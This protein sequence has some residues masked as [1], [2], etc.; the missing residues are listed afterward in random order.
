MDVH[1][2]ESIWLGPDK[3]L[4][5]LCHLSKNLYN[6][7]NY[8]IRQE[9]FSTGRWVRYY[10]LWTNLKNSPNYQGLPAQT[11]QQTL[12]IVDACWRA[13]QIAMEDYTVNPEKYFAMPRFPK[14]K[15]KDGEFILAFSNQQ[16]KLR[17]GMLRLTNGIIEVRTRLSKGTKITGARIMPR[18]VGYN[19]EITYDKEVKEK[20]VQ[21]K[22]RTIEGEMANDPK[23]QARPCRALGIDPGLNNLLTT[24]N[25]IGVPPI[26]F[27]GGPVKSINQFY[28][29]RRAELRSQ[30][31]RQGIETGP[32]MQKLSLKRNRKIDCFFHLVSKL[33]IW[34]CLMWKIDTIVLGR[35]KLWKQ[36][37]NLGKRTNQNFVN[38]PF[39]KLYQMI[40]YKAEEAGIRVIEI[41]EAYT[42]M[43]SFL[44]WESIEHHE[45]YMGK[46]ISRGLFRSAKGILIN[47]DVNGAYNHMR[48][49]IPESMEKLKQKVMADGIEAVGIHPVRAVLD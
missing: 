38:I 10:E 12:R 4:G 9:K 28:N 42:S 22:E 16:V 37:I 36:E 23:E 6:E 29:K 33:L 18:G 43:C 31:A 19:L 5:H 26:A 27:K 35:N 17:N 8:L 21:E 46:R 11:A 7:A 1:R 25:N 44:D 3:G 20:R 14:Y 13:Y 47:A 49:A 41:D 2:T 32:K 34:Y 24:V 45:V 40:K 15:R 39:Y 48:N 30:Y